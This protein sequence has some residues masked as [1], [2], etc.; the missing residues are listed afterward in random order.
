MSDNKNIRKQYARMSAKFRYE[1]RRLEM[2]I[3]ERNKYYEENIKR[4]NRTIER[5]RNKYPALSTP[6][7]KYLT[8]EDMARAMAEMQ[9][10]RQEGAMSLKSRKRSEANLQDYLESKNIPLTDKQM[11]RLYKF[12]E[13][14]RT[15]SKGT[16][17]KIGSDLIMELGYNAVRGNFSKEMIIRNV[18]DWI[19]S[20]TNE[21]RLR[22]KFGNSSN[23]DF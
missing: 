13:Y 6:F 17:L 4:A 15:T 16:D 2:K 5:F 3:N 21:P 12:L 23:T 18:E 9:E 14:I 7:G 8:E 10:A 22:R 20:G 11:D 19:R 1:L